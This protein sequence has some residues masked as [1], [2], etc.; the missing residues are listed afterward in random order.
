MLDG[1]LIWRN[2]SEAEFNMF[3]WTESSIKHFV[4]AKYITSN[5]VPVSFTPTITLSLLY[6]YS[7][8][9]IIW[10]VCILDSISIKI[11]S[12]DKNQKIPDK[13]L[14][15]LLKTIS[16]GSSD[17]ELLNRMTVLLNSQRY[18]KPFW[19]KQNI[20]LQMTLSIDL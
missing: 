11:M 12:S 4:L 20:F 3:G 8:L 17:L 10:D 6:I 19:V 9:G 15:R 5:V 13:V 16:S 1:L 18:M 2:F 7:V 14:K